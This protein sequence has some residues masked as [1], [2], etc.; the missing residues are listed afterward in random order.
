MGCPWQLTVPSPP[1]V[2]TTS[3]PHSSQR[4]RLPASLATNASPMLVPLPSVRPTLA[5][6]GRGGPTSALRRCADKCLAGRGSAGTA[7]QR[8]WCPRL[9][10]RVLGVQEATDLAHRCGE[11]VWVAAVGDEVEG[12]A[13]GVHV[14]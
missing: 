4:T 5:R 3:A 8:T 9:S 13:A 12:A 2:T 14:G 7:A 1:L 6:P 11:L 10:A